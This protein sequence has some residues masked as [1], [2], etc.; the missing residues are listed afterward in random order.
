MRVAAFELLTWPCTAQVEMLKR[1]DIHLAGLHM[2]SNDLTRE[3]AFDIHAVGDL[4]LYRKIGT[5]I[6]FKGCQ[7]VGKGS[8]KALAML[9]ATRVVC[10]RDFFEHNWQNVGPLLW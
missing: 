4:C 8:A 3:H 5:A 9:D 7:G 10:R 1:F 6:A 2:C